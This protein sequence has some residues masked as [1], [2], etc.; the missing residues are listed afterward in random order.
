MN[1]LLL[2][3]LFCSAMACTNHVT[4]HP[5]EKPPASWTQQ[6]V[7]VRSHSDSSTKATLRRFE[8][9]DGKWQPIGDAVAV[10]LGRT[11]L[12]WG[13]G[14]HPPQHGPQKR[15]GDGK[16]PSGLFFFGQIFGYAPASAANFKVPYV[17]ADEALEC[18]DD[19]R[20]RFYNQ[21][22][23]SKLVQKDWT[24]SELMR[25]PDHQ[26]RWG[27]VVNHNFPAQAGGGSCIFLHIWREPGS[28]TLGCTAMAED[29]LLTL[30]H[31][32]DPAKFPQ[33]LQVTEAEYPAFQKALALPD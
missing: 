12:A 27:I 5:G 20:S 29:D 2:F 23:D 15:E 10:S 11:G 17:P 8:K 9:M 24:S 1:N 32:L 26:Y 31:W 6:L 18:V 16:S 22:V 14:E 4:L 19:S 30:L 7:V 3:F 33:L 13:R 28:P 25:R 21:L